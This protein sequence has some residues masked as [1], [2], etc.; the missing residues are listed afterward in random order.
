MT[1][2]KLKVLTEWQSN[3]MT[4]NRATLANEHKRI[5]ETAEHSEC[6]NTFLLHG[7]RPENN[8]ADLIVKVYKCFSGE[9][10]SDEG[11]LAIIEMLDSDKPKLPFLVLF[12]SMTQKKNAH[13]ED[14][15]WGLDCVWP[16]FLELMLQF[17][18]NEAIDNACAALD[19]ALQD[20]DEPARDEIRS[21]F[22][23]L[24]TSPSF[25]KISTTW[26][27]MFY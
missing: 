6:L 7:G 8:V 12:R 27:E 26:K 11:A 10:D 21:F 5:M 17:E 15:I 13:G 23:A 22:K 25:E 1:S 18:R 3:E 14:L 9:N 19:G 16:V 24:A 2:K 20:S 4:R